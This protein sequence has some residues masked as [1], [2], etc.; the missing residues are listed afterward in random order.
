MIEETNGKLVLQKRNVMFEGKILN[1]KESPW[2]KLI[3]DPDCFLVDIDLTVIKQRFGLTFEA[4]VSQFAFLSVLKNIKIFSNLSNAKLMQI[5][6][7][8]KYRKCVNKEVIIK[9]GDIGDELFFVKSGKID[10]YSN[11]TYLRSL[12]DKGYFGERSLF[13]D[14]ARSATAFSIGVSELYSISKDQIAALFDKK[15]INFFKERLSL[16]DDK[17]NLADLIF[18]SVLGSGSYGDVFLVSSQRNSQTYALKTI[19][20]YKILKE[21][22]TE[23]LESER[24]VLLQIDH[25][26][27]MKLVKT[28]KD[29]MNIY[30][31]QE[32][33]HGKELFDVI[34]D[35]GV[36]SHDECKF[37]GAM[38]ML[39]VDFLHS[40]GFVYRDMK[41][42]NLLVNGEGFIKLI[43]FGTVKEVTDRCLTILGTPHYMAPEVIL[44]E[45]Y[46]F[47]VDFW[48]IGLSLNRS[49]HV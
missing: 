7:L 44:G 33:I 11:N 38:M 37:Y 43:D 3:A 23:N 21:K 28:L 2:D 20:K 4:L 35:I 45:G 49:L 42:E 26:F 36:L 40:K 15:Q 47:G 18:H 6:K 39:A 5:S 14:E 34:R 24:K 46:S 13:L 17:V 29:D 30:F 31:L 25:P 12:T 10:F 48:S 22:L 27:I 41:P 8:A 19:N 1:G 16:Q 9:E 32:L